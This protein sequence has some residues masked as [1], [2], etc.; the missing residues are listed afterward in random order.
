MKCLGVEVS[1]TG[2]V[3]FINLWNWFYILKVG[4]RW[5]MDKVRKW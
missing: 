1:K 5:A 3:L 4:D 2:S